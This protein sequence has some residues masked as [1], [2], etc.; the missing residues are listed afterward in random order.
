MLSRDRR[1]ILYVYGYAVF[2]GLVAL[3]LP[4]GVQA[5]IGLVLAERVSSSWIILTAVVTLGVWLSG[6][7]QVV[8]LSI[9]EVL[10]QRIFTRA[11]FEFAYRI[12]RL[13]SK[14]IR[15]VYTP[16]LMNRFFDILN[17]QKGLSKLL[18]DFSS[19]ALQILFGLLLLSFY[20]PVFIFFGVGLLA[21][22][23]TIF[24]WTGKWGLASSL[25]ESKWKYAMAH[26][27][28]DLARGMRTFKLAGTTDLPL[29]RTDELVSQYLSARKAHFRVLVLQYGHV[30]AF[31][32]LITAGLLAIGG[33]LVI[34][35]QI[36]VGQFVAS[37][38]II[39][40]TMNSAEKLILTMEPIYDILTAVEKI[41]QV[42]DLPIEPEQEGL[43]LSD[44]ERAGASE[45]GWS[46]R[47]RD[48]SLEGLMA[49]EPGVLNDIDLDIAAGERVCVSGPP[50]SGKSS[51][52][53]LMA[54]LD[55]G[56]SGIRLINGI[57]VGNIDGCALR[58]HIGDA[59]EDEVI[60]HGTVYE[61][62]GLGRP[63][64]DFAAVQW[65]AQAVGL[66]ATI[67]QWPQGYD[68]VLETGGVGL[69]SSAVRRLFLARAIAC[70]PRL[71]VLDQP[72]KSQSPEERTRLASYLCDRQHP[73]TL[74]IASNEPEIQ[75]A[76]D[77]VI[78]LSN[79]R[80]VSST[81]SPTVS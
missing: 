59:L 26:W 13:E 5:I 23:T 62:I 32:G 22:L 56:A 34:E 55:D 31:K 12:P 64:V 27:L 9:T 24:V 19:S 28:E 11:A 17:V 79:G 40:L 65:A 10:Q 37:E 47:Y 46:L 3:S 51:L 78:T 76:C 38:I 57:P 7:L 71:L 66:E 63:G 58:S 20:H 36:N 54:G 6:V 4:L 81:P 74:V 44:L 33:Y 41:A 80:V 53:R 50:G 42:T 69:P 52:L 30:V 16:E 21:M 1:D 48:V 73:W 43:G 29:Q 49:G 72:L 25:E 15:G 18:L 60:F 70:R 61:N 39:I 77:R 14:A 8:Q 2:N 68:T 67:T 75:R 35:N 45:R